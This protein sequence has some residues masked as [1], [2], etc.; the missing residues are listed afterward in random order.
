MSSNITK[1]LNHLHSHNPPQAEYEVEGIQS[2]L[3]PYQK[4]ALN[5]MVEREK[6]GK[7]VGVKEGQDLLT[8]QIWDE[9][10]QGEGD[11][12]KGGILADEMGLGRIQSTSKS[13]TIITS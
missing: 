2:P 13:T 8:K 5:W 4:R 7:I 6:S 1:F 9:K 11:V 3:R 10:L 12:V